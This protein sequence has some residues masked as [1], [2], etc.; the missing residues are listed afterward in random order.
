MVRAQ[1]FCDVGGY[2]EALIAGEDPELCV[3]L[4]ARGWQVH[5][6]AEEMTL[7]DASMMRFGQWWLRIRRSGYAFAQGAYLHG[8]PPERHNVRESRRAWLWGLALPLA[9]VLATLALGPWALS[10]VAI[11]PLQVL[12][13]YVLG[14]GSPGDRGLQAVFHTLGRFP[15]ALGQLQFLRDR[16]LHRHSGLIEYK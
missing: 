14:S 7:H 4:R 10:G 16:L 5:A 12:R 13:L 11:Y 15:E 3:R 8:A 1:A 2:C 9:I 6:L